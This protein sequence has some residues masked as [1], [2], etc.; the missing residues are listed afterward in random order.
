MTA[1]S[2]RY[3]P[4]HADPADDAGLDAGAD[5][6]DGTAAREHALALLAASPVYA[7]V[8]RLLGLERP[9]MAALRTEIGI[10]LAQLPPGWHVLPAAG[11][12]HLVVGPAGAFAMTVRHHPGATVAVD[13]DNVKVDG[14]NQRCIGDVRRQTARLAKML[15]AA[16]G[17]PVPVHAVLAVSGA[18][19]GFGVKRQPRGV[20]VVN[21]RSVTPYLHAQPTVLDAAAVDRL[22]AVATTR[23]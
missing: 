2:I 12:D 17:K 7:R 13:G 3:E 6:D 15:S 18:Q 11:V 20:T 9:G 16:A 14:R 22:V 21:R 19:Q 10:R 4:R 5:V 1:S 8:A 23:A